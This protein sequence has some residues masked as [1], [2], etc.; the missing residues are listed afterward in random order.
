MM[1]NGESVR[2]AASDSAGAAWRHVDL[3]LHSPWSGHFS[4]L[5]E[6]DP[7][8]DTGVDELARAYVEALQSA[9]IEIAAITDYNGIREPGFS[10]IR[11]LASEKGITVLPGVELDIP[12][13]GK[14]GLHIVAIF[15]SDTDVDV[16]ERALVGIDKDPSTSLVDG[17][18]LSRGLRLRDQLVRCLLDLREEHGCLLVVPHPES[19]D[20]GLMN[21]YRAGVAAQFLVD[22]QPDAI[23]HL[24]DGAEGRLRDTGILTDSFFSD[25]ALVEFSDAHGL[26]EIGR[27]ELADGTR[28]ATYIKLSA[29][30]L[31]ALRLAMHDPETRI[32][33][34]ERPEPEH[35][36]FLRMTVS[37][38][39]GF[40]SDL[41]LRWN[42]D[43]NVLIGGRGAGKS[44]V[45]ESLR[46]ALGS[47]TYVD[48]SSRANLVE[49]ALGSGGEV[50]VEVERPV[51]PG[52]EKRFRI[53][54]VLN[55]DPRVFEE[56][57]REPLGI[58]PLEV[59]GNY[60]P[61][62]FGQ[63]EIQAVASNESQRLRLVDLLVGGEADAADRRVRAVRAKLAENGQR[64]RAI[65][66]RI[67][68]AE[69]LEQQL[70]NIRHRINVYEESGVAD[71][72][73][74]HTSLSR[75]RERLSAARTQVSDFRGDWQELTETVTSSLRRIANGLGA[76]ET[77]EEGTSF[78]ELVE[79]IETVREELTELGT[80]AVNRLE[81]L[82]SRFS[83]TEGS[84]DASVGELEGEL[85]EVRA[86]LDQS[87]LDPDQL[88]ELTRRRTALE[89]Q[90]QEV[91]RS[92][93]ELGEAESERARLLE[94]Y[95]VARR[96]EN[97]IRQRRCN[98]AQAR[99]DG[100]LELEVHFKGHREPYQ[101][102]LSE[103]LRGS[104]VT[105][106]AIEALVDSDAPDGATLART[107]RE[108]PQAV[109]ERYGLTEAYSQRVV[110]WFNED[111]ERTHDLELLVPNDRVEMRLRVGDRM[112]PV[113]QLSLGERATAVL[114]LL[115]AMERRILIVDQPEDDLDNRFVFE[116][117][118]A[119]LRDAKTGDGRRQVIAATHNA[120]IPVLGDAELIATLEASDSSAA[121]ITRAS[122]DDPEVRDHV[123][124]LLEGGEEAFRLR[125]EKYGGV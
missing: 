8:T 45:I 31:D 101:E 64:L 42:P 95:R 40:L 80:A 32:A 29:T 60:P 26:E 27:K 33:V 22:L 55:E 123:R 14:Y 105:S 72:L 112:R 30:S 67:E 88:L 11:D 110:D 85:D 52:V 89:G 122:I 53:S 2:A 124:S 113:E 106:S 51:R 20:K 76:D 82:E 57:S 34:G 107:I 87:E 23:E 86:S 108:G 63:R 109:Q 111:L 71:K 37:G 119:L 19:H 77:A 47:K 44:A 4:G 6:V 125:Y 28:R 93:V 117:V 91:E 100:R 1:S 121:V 70:K 61:M 74:A 66:K 81:G 96:Q 38:E 54:R 102:A 39:S 104:R 78:S 56:G 3:H 46:Y 43:L 103:L 25:V 36:R 15:P 49:H 92:E 7:R 115:F 12:N 9:G 116:D 16:I 120:N 97:Q 94:E 58:S 73:R 48:A 68:R 5:S 90:L 10:R 65:R 84:L 69:E 13:E 18:G 35:V 17:D 50:T 118:V 21:T 75:D 99:L 114:L 62:I 83:S 98:E 79:A 24:S 41:D 59:F